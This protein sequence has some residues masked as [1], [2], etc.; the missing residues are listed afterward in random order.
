[1][2][3]SPKMSSGPIL[4]LMF[5]TVPNFTLGNVSLCFFHLSHLN[6]TSLYLVITAIP[7]P[8]LWISPLF[9]VWP[10]HFYSVYCLLNEV[11]HQTYALALLSGL[12]QRKCSREGPQLPSIPWRGRER[13]R[14]ADYEIN[15]HYKPLKPHNYLMKAIVAEVYHW[16][17]Y[18]SFYFI[19][20]FLLFFVSDKGQEKK[21]WYSALQ[22]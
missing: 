7:F 20:F 9:L 10:H 8:L 3:V 13:P 6:T 11:D 2:F 12:F 19:N 16:E 14:V 17:K 21:P 18:I 4:D 15:I 22:S 1:M 5:Y